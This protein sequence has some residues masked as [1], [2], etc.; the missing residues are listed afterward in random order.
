MDSSHD[1]GGITQQSAAALAF[2]VPAGVVQDQHA[3]G[4]LL[5]QQFK[6]AHK[7]A[8]VRGVLSTS[9]TGTR[10]I[11]DQEHWP[12]RRDGE[13]ERTGVLWPFQVRRRPNPMNGVGRVLVK[14]FPS[15]D[16]PGPS[17]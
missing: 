17:T 4:R 9:A 1:V 13:S 5:L 14:P 12:Y 16:S 2:G 7:R 11:H 3:A 10:R 8:H 15:S 6:S